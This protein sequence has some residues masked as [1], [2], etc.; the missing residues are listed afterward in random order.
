MPRGNLSPR[1]M[2]RIWAAQELADK[3]RRQ[4]VKQEREAFE[5]AKKR[6]DESRRT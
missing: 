6:R 2:A 1:R 3:N 4:R 5:A